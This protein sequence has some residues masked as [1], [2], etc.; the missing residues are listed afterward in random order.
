MMPGVFVDA[1]CCSSQQECMGQAAKVPHARPSGFDS[2]KISRVAWARSHIPRTL[3]LARLRVSATV[4]DL[5]SDL[6]F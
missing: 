6:F 2:D 3:Y 1:L 5:A 4:D